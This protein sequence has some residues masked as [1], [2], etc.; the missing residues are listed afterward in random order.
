[1]LLF[2]CSQKEE[3]RVHKVRIAL[4][5]GIRPAVWKEFLM[6]FGPIKIFEF[7]GSTEGN[8][9]FL[10][11]T[12]KIG[13]V[14]RAGIFSKVN[15]IKSTNQPINQPTKK[16]Q[17]KGRNYKELEIVQGRSCLLQPRCSKIRFTETEILFLA[18]YLTL[19]SVHILWSENKYAEQ[20]H[21]SWNYCFMSPTFC[22]E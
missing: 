5:N 2:G 19:F 17:T 3:D 18:P 9:S 8:L 10:N 22:P 4:G 21:R 14:G 6:S 13:A 16:K 15:I 7:Y 20:G 11:Y 12:N 1:M